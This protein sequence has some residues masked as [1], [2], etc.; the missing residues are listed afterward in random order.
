MQYIIV[1]VT[2]FFFFFFRTLDDVI[3]L[4]MHGMTA[5]R[6]IRVSGADWPDACH[7]LAATDVSLFADKFLNSS[8]W[9][10]TRCTIIC[11]NIWVIK[12]AAVVN[13]TTANTGKLESP[14]SR[15]ILR[16]TQSAAVS[17]YYR[18]YNIV[19]SHAVSAAYNIMPTIFVCKNDDE[20][21]ECV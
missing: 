9:H 18:H 7:M 10:R 12:T 8:Q 13:F 5:V 17:N 4:F 15:N 3:T 6:E 14:P 11:I 19:F 21:L 16:V 20:V 2:F 1:R